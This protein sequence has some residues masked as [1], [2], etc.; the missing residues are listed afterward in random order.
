[1][2][3]P[4]LTFEWPSRHRI[5][6]FLPF[7][8]LVAAL[9]HAAIFFLF[10]VKHPAPRS[11][12]TNPARFYFLP[13][14]S[15]EYSRIESALHSS[16]PALFAPG[17]GLRDPGDLPSATYTPQYAKAATAWDE[18]PLQIQK[19]RDD[20]IFQGPVRIPLKKPTRPDSRPTPS[21]RLHASPEIAHRIPSDPAMPKFQILAGTSPQPA[22]FL[23][24]LSPHGKVVHAFTDKSSGDDNLD[25]AALAFLGKLEFSPSQ[26]TTTDWGFLEFHW[27][28]EVLPAI[29]P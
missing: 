22:T 14:S 17:R 12:A 29:T 21:T 18:P 4:T 24:A 7:A 28:S 11:A 27:G 26:K 6:L 23:I 5:H 2:K 13:S 15:H 9:L 3:S 19:P 8:V 20:R 10:S 16:D 1:M 25:R